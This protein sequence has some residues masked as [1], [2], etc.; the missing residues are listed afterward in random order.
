LVAGNE[1]STDENL[2]TQSA[3]MKI[4]EEQ[5]KNLERDISHFSS[6]S[7]VEKH[8]NNVTEVFVNSEQKMRSPEIS[9]TIKNENFREITAIVELTDE[10]VDQEY[11]GN[12]ETDENMKRIASSVLLTKM[13]VQ[14]KIA[15]YES[16]SGA[17][18]KSITESKEKKKPDSLT[19]ENFILY[20][21]NLENMSSLSSSLSSIP[22]E[23]NPEDEISSVEESSHEGS[24]VSEALLSETESIDEIRE[25]DES[26]YLKYIPVDTSNIDLLRRTTDLSDVIEEDSDISELTDRGCSEKFVDLIGTKSD[27]RLETCFCQINTDHQLITY[28]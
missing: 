15:L 25:I 22:Y 17:S 19:D 8:S 27:E 14:E 10:L 12:I 5:F 3:E 9:K 16:L 13:N 6:S 18:E 7:V 24:D 11:L 1:N 2:S 21:E 20:N 28:L 23:Q 4:S 26:T